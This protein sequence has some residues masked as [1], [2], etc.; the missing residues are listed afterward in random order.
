MGTSAA[1]FS[2]DVGILAG[3]DVS[4]LHVM[5]PTEANDELRE[6]MMAKVKST[7]MKFLVP[8]VRHVKVP[9]AGTAFSTN[10]RITSGDG[11]SLLAVLSA[12]QSQTETGIANYNISNLATGTKAI[13]AKVVSQQTRLDSKTLSDSRQNCADMDD[14]NQIKDALKDSAISSAKVWNYNRCYFDS[15]SN[16][17]SAKWLADFANYKDGKDLMEKDLNYSIEATTANASQYLH[18]WIITQGTMEIT[19]QG[20]VNLF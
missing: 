4:D 6:S 17:S 12:V 19:P 5:V 8:R 3:Y 18:L 14:Y 9:T 10:Y 16:S 15:W 13:G 20:T 2:T 11:H 7:G 1:D